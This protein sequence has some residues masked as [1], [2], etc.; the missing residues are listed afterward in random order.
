MT[1]LLASTT[2]RKAGAVFLQAGGVQ[3]QFR[4]R[5][6]ALD[7]EVDGARQQRP[8]TRARH[9]IILGA[10]AQ[11]PQLH[12]FVV[13]PGIDDQGHF[14]HG[15]AEAFEGRESR[16]VGEV[17]IEQYGVELAA[18]QQEQAIREAGSDGEMDV[19]QN[20]ATEFGMEQPGVARIVFQNQ[21]F[22]PAAHRSQRL[23]VVHVCITP[24]VMVAHAGGDSQVFAR[25]CRSN[26]VA[27]VKLNSRTFMA[28]A[29][30]S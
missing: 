19:D 16:T 17:E 21:N 1:S 14:R 3:F 22:H 6:A 23:V 25:R 15:G 24:L 2:S 4:A 29:T 20:F 10:A 26:R 30:M 27:S 12:L 9:H 11:R 28:G 7:G 13:A 8:V 18:G 5:A